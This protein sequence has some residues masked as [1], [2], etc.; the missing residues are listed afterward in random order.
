NHDYRTQEDR[1]ADED[2][3]PK[4]INYRFEHA[5]WQF[6]GLDTTD[7]QR[8][9][10]TSVQ[11]HTLTWL[12]ET[13]PKLDKKR[14]T[15]LFTHF[16]LGPWVITRPENAEQLLERFK[17]YNLQAVFCGHFHAFTERHWGKVTLTTN[18]CCSFSRKN[19]DGSKEKG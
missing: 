17:E 15:I 13:L 6:L 7:G 12:D 3:F 1:K 19:H 10:G 14:P 2:L 9:Q 18:R 11:P 4:R 16:P 8:G 5:G